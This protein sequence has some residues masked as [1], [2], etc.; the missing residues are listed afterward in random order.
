MSA[1]NTAETATLDAW[2]G[3]TTLGP[4]NW[5]VAAYTA[6]PGET[7]GGTEATGGGY[8]RVTVAN[9]STNFPAATAGAPSSKTTGAA[10]TFP[11]STGAWSS[12]ANIVALGFHTAAGDNL[13]FYMTIQAGDQQAITAANQQ[14]NFPAGSITITMD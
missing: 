7:G 6:A 3:S 8:A 9:N 5:L 13:R 1:T 4:A 14:L 10:I 11:T 2:F 12:S